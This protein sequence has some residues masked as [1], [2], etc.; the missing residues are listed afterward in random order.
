MIVRAEADDDGTAGRSSGR[1]PALLDGLCPSS[2]LFNIN[3]R[4][5]DH[6]CP[7]RRS[8]RIVQSTMKHMSGVDPRPCQRPGQRSL[9]VVPQNLRRPTRKL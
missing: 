6:E 4:L 7:Y 1:S 8:R 2:N 5:C 3:I 9:S